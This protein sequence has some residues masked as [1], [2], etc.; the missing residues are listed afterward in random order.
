MRTLTILSLAL[1]LLIG[2]CA[3]GS[4]DGVKSADRPASRRASRDVLTLEEIQTASGAE[5]AYEVVRRL[6][7]E[8]LRKRG[9][10]SISTPEPNPIVVYVNGANVGGVE[11]LRQIRVFEL[12]EIRYVN[13][14]DATTRYGTDHS[15]GALEVVTGT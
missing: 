10:T 15:G 13:A 12:K 7:P 2:A 4:A 8:F 1:S 5:N 9:A 6:R 11:M 3:S 14:R